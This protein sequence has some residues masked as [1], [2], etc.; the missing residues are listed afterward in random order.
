MLHTKKVTKK[1]GEALKRSREHSHK[2]IDRK[3]EKVLLS[4]EHAA[5]FKELLSNFDDHM[6]LKKVHYTQGR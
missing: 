3:L 4:I 2:E 5:A 6:K 1:L